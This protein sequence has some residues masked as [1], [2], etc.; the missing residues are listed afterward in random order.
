MSKD[1]QPPTTEITIAAD[2]KLLQEILARQYGRLD[3]KAAR[4][5]LEN[6]YTPVWN[7]EEFQA[8]FTVHDTCPPYVYVSS[9]ETGQLGTVI[10]V[11]SPRFYF[12]FNPTGS[13]HG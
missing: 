8:A 12:L 6:C 7:E 10:Y 4:A 13:D 2:D 9:K 3:E 5:E 1:V 11:D